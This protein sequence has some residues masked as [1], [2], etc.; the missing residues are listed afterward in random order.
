MG[1]QLRFNQ[2]STVLHTPP[3]GSVVPSDSAPGSAGPVF[4]I[5]WADLRAWIASTV[6]LATSRVTGLDATLSALQNQVDA[7]GS[8]TYNRTTL[9]NSGGDSTITPAAGIRYQT[10][11]VSVS[12]SAETRNLI[13][14]LTNRVAGDRMRLVVSLPAIAGIIIHVRNATAG[15]TLL[16]TFFTS[17][18]Q[19]MT[20][21]VDLAYDGTAWTREF[22]AQTTLPQL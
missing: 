9:A 15:G 22:D 11:A 7:V 6:A 10:A 16:A 1:E 17:T 8:N 3:E 12:G 14:A 5:S 21:I 2:I 4:L 20:G 13:A 19:A 18:D